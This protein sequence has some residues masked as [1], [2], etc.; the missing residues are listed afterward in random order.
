MYLE[1]RGSDCSYSDWNSA[2]M[3]LLFKPPMLVN[4]SFDL[5][6]PELHKIDDKWY[7]IFTADS[8]ADS[9]PPETDMYCDYACPAVNHR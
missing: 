1:S 8:D 7:V 9:P 5:W 6:A 3:K 2:E 4:Y